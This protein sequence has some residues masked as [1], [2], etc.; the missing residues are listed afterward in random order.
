[1]SAFFFQDCS[2]QSGLVDHTSIFVFSSSIIKLFDHFIPGAC[3]ALII[4][5]IFSYRDLLRNKRKTWV[6][7]DVQSF[8]F[9]SCHSLPTNRASWV[10]S[11]FNWRV[12]IKLKPTIYWQS[13]MGRH[14]GQTCIVY[15]FIYQLWMITSSSKF[16]DVFYSLSPMF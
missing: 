16:V 9:V 1:M 10:S 2:C 6:K 3:S 8:L 5:I 7:C 4:V 12:Y 13:P 14:N 15:Y 11:A